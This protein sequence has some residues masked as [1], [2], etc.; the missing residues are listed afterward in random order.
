VI[1]DAADLPVGVLFDVVDQRRNFAEDMH[2]DVR[3]TIFRVRREVWLWTSFWRP[4]AAALRRC[5][6][7][8]L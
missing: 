7:H 2:E 3:V 5:V 6:G 8:L 1:T 4:Q